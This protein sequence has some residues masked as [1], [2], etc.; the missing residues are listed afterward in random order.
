MTDNWDTNKEKIER[1]FLL[2]NAFWLSANFLIVFDIYWYL[3]L[4]NLQNNDF[5]SNCS[6]LVHLLLT[7]FNWVLHSFIGIT[8]YQLWGSITE[9]NMSKN[10]IKNKQIKT[11]FARIESSRL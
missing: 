7:P 6:F 10:V 4:L 8:N 2:R 5:G 11:A 9:S 3:S 1:T